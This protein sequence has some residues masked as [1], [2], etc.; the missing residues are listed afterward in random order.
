MGIGHVIYGIASDVS[1][2]ATK[3]VNYSTQN[4]ETPLSNT[5][6]RT[7]AMSR[8]EIFSFLIFFK[9]MMFHSTLSLIQEKNL[10]NV[11]SAAISLIFTLKAIQY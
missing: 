3:N 2:F 7:L 4:E 6:I 11:Q 10:T 5:L 8:F 1:S 9:G